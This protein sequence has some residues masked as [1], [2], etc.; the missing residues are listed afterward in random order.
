MGVQTVSLPPST[1][2]QDERRR[3]HVSPSWIQMLSPLSFPLIL[4]WVG[5]ALCFMLFRYNHFS[6]EGRKRSSQHEGLGGHLPREPCLLWPP[7]GQPPLPGG[8]LQ[9]FFQLARGLC[10]PRFSLFSFMSRVRLH[11]HPLHPCP[12]PMLT[13]L[14]PQR[15]AAATIPHR[16]HRP[17]P[18][19][20]SP[21][22]API[23][24]ALQY[25]A[26][27]K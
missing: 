9:P 21:V 18:S 26:M 1:P 13:F 12:S 24:D 8:H 4:S 6:A 15:P 11:S 25:P 17:A 27:P 22:L 16:Q 2:S 5:S 7:L 20:S 14:H 23:L 19:T 3:E 10:E